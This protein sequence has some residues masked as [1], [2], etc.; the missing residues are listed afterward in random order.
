MSS[1]RTLPAHQVSAAFLAWTFATTLSSAVCAQPTVGAT[2]EP[3]AE[4]SPHP[5]RPEPEKAAPQERVPNGFGV[6][7]AL[8]GVPSDESSDQSPD[9]SRAPR[10]TRLA[11]YRDIHAPVVLRAGAP[12]RFVV[13]ADDP[14]GHP[15][16]YEARGLPPGSQFDPT[17]QVFTWTPSAETLGSFSPIFVAKN[18]SL[19]GTLLVQLEVSENR[20]PRVE[21]PS[22]QFFVD[23]PATHGIFAHDPDGDALTLRA[24]GLPNGARFDPVTHQLSWQPKREDVGTHTIALFVADGEKTSEA[25]VKI[26]VDDPN[27]APEQEEWKSFLQPGLGYAVYLPRD[28]ETYSVFHGIDMQLSIVSWIHRNENRGPSHGRLYVSAQVLRDDEKTTGPLFV[29]SL[30]LTL[31]LERNPKRSF[32]LPHYGVEIGGM[33]EDSIGGQFQS[34]FFGGVHI[35]S[36]RNLLVN[37]E[38][39]YL[40]VPRAMADLAGFSA[41]ANAVFSLW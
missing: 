30:G 20:A 18:S 36:S 27:A 28:Q 25:Q 11:P 1:C 12:V 3:K 14:N 33:A 39:G 37:A 13:H 22:L 40:L 7:P 31:S 34:R 29:Y 21:T 2:L 9:Q 8:R 19:E 35:W 10:F 24:S 26:R 16:V 5:A 41:G 32:L 15:L 38:A 6:S 17:T 4:S 23:Q